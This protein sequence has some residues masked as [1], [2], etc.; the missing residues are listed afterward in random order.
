MKLKYVVGFVV[1]AACVAVGVYMLKTSMTP[2]LP[3]RE[4]MEASGREVQIIGTIV[5]GTTGVDAKTG[6]R[7]FTLKDEAGT[8][9]DVETHENLPANFEHSKSVVAVGE[10]NNGIFTASRILVKCPSKYEKKAKGE[11]PESGSGK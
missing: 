1:I 5:K 7:R 6:L 9:L 2:Y 3:F 8:R 4:A 10:Y 11:S